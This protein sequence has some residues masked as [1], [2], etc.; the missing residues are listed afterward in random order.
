MIQ[1][2]L[3]LHERILRYYLLPKQSLFRRDYDTFPLHT[4]LSFNRRVLRQCAFNGRVIKGNFIPP[5]K[6]EFNV[7]RDVLYR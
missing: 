7:I 2:A 1:L 6:A 5:T 3:D 4:S